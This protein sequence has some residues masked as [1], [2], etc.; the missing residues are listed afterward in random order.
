MKPAAIRKLCMSFPGAT[1]SIQWGG[2]RVFKIGGK[3]FA[4]ISAA[5]DADAMSFKASDESFRLLTELPGLMPAPY[6]ARAQWVKIEP[7]ASL[8]EGDLAA[9]LRRA[10]E[11]VAGRLPKKTRDALLTNRTASTSSP[12][13]RS[14]RAPSGR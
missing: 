10:Y 9:Y 4:V 8:P 11:I 6:L 7:L 14:S 3:M 1:E 5:R 12:A 13:R 2:E